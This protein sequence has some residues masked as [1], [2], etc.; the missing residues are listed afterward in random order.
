MGNEGR[1]VSL[2]AV[3]AGE[4]RSQ[5]RPRAPE[6]AQKQGRQASTHPHPLWVAV[7]RGELNL[8]GLYRRGRWSGAFGVGE[9]HTRRNDEEDKT[10]DLRRGGTTCGRRLGG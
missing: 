9:R 2:R 3:N 6:G 10:Q 4:G 7:R 1:T 8:L 5:D